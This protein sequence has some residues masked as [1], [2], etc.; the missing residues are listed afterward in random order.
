M[1]TLIWRG[2]APA[3]AQVS[4]ITVA[5][6]WATNDT[7]VI[8]INGKSLTLTVGAAAATTDVAAA[9]VAM[10]N[11]AAVVGTETRSDTGDNIPEFQEVTATLS[12]STCI[13]TANTAGIPF[14][15]TVSET[16]A[17]SGTLS[18]ATGTA[19]Q[20]P[21]D[22]STAA[23][24]S[25]GAVPVNSDDVYFTNNDV[26]CLYGLDQNAVTLTSLT[27][28]QS[29][30]GRLGLPTV[31]ELGGYYE[32]RPTYLMIGATTQKIGE[33]GGPGSGRIKI[34][35]GTVQTT[36]TIRNSGQELEEGL[37]SILWKGTHA[38]NAVNITRGK[39]GAA[40]FPGETAVIATLRVGYQES[41]DS[42]AAV[43]CGSGVT[44][45]TI[46]QSGGTLETASNVTTV[47]M[48]GGT[49]TRWAGTLGTL[50]LD[51]GTV[52]YLS[53]GTM[54]TVKV[55]S[56][57]VLNFTKDMRSRTVTNAEIY[58][59][60]EIHDPFQT[61]TWSNGIDLIRCSPSECVLD[62]GTHLTLTPSAV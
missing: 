60:G 33:G 41:I 24:W 52:H 23:N 61:V 25:T 5:N 7:G 13:L 48:T 9:L 26:D 20:G 53:T 15:A 54:T 47:N 12:G 35:N 3:R 27:I 32:Y 31:N 55:G 4:T 17:G 28:D 37:E 40:V 19:S 44:L 56:D 43:R 57:G 10:V 30:T 22:W 39:L 21:N 46:N 45:T 16:T 36:L 62:I 59:R 14:T 1:G 11:G 8:T 38:S 58:E 49:H 29:Y 2:D 6:T 34:N 42:D 18:I 50:N 51:G